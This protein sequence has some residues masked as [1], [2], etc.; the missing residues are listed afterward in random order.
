MLNPFPKQGNLTG[1]K[2]LAR[3]SH[4]DQ[5]FRHSPSFKMGGEASQHYQPPQRT[6]SIN[7][8]LTL[9]CEAHSLPKCV[10]SQNALIR[11]KKMLQIFLTVNWCH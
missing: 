10:L 8:T 6:M 7:G 11:S 1:D 4:G 2:E 9:D 5:L 3:S